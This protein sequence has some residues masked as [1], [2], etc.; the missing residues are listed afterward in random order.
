M[1]GKTSFQGGQFSGKT[2]FQGVHRPWDAYFETLFLKGF[3]ISYSYRSGAYKIA[4]DSADGDLYFFRNYSG[5]ME[6]IGLGGPH[7]L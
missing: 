6:R 7:V 3:D 5:T 1:S 2:R 4:R